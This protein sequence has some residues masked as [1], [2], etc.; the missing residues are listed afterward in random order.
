ML[1]SNQTHWHGLL[2]EWSETSVQVVAIGSWQVLKGYHIGG[3]EIWTRQTTRVEGGARIGFNRLGF[4]TDSTLG[5][6]PRHGT[7]F[8]LTPADGVVATVASS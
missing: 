8:Q 4:E 3:C 6:V 2:S 1:Q 7:Y 5:H